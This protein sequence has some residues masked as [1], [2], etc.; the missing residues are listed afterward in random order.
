[1][2]RFLIGAI[3]VFTNEFELSAYITFALWVTMLLY[4]VD[5]D[6]RI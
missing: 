3:I 5:L 6:Y 1:M 2:R 4:Q